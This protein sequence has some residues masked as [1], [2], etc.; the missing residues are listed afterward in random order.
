LLKDNGY[1][2]FSIH[3]FKPEF[4]NRSNAH[5]AMGFDRFYS[6]DELIMDETLGWGLTDNSLF[7]QSIEIMQ[8]EDKPFY[9]LI[10][11]LTNHHP[12]DAYAE[13][14]TFD[15]TGVEG[16]LMQNYIKSVNKADEAIGE[17]IQQLKDKGFYQNS[18]LVFYGDHEGITGE[19]NRDLDSLMGLEESDIFQQ[20]EY[21]KVPLIIHVPDEELK[22]NIS[23]VAGQV[24]VLPTLLNLL[25]ERPKYY[26]GNDLLNT[27]NNLVVLRDGSYVD[28]NYIYIRAID[29]YYDKNTKV[30]VDNNKVISR[31]NEALNQLKLSDIILDGNLLEYYS[32]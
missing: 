11:T 26:F 20:R 25:G 30:I 6:S 16:E 17:F 7:K 14:S 24:D 22:G 1:S 2:T 15:T 5:K 13:L 29:K 8:K 28:D 21:E 31:K 9:S 23:K 12:Y 19:D 10:I 18:I 3:G 32:K 27:E 4:W